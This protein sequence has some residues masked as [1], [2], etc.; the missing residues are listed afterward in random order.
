MR[1][2]HPTHNLVDGFD[3]GLTERVDVSVRDLAEVDSASDTVFDLV[4]LA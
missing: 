2:L 4:G 3:S 1:G